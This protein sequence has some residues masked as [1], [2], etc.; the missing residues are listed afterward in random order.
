LNTL[1]LMSKLHPNDKIDYYSK[2][3]QLW[4]YADQNLIDH[5]YGDWYAGGIDKQPEM[6]TAMKGHIWKATYHQTRSLINC[7][8][9]L[10]K[11]PSEGH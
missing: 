7:I 6:K 8:K 9:H 2:F 3:V 10:K 5:Q 1:L 4:N 11:S